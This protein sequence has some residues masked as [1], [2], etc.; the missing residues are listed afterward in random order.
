MINAVLGSLRDARKHPE[1]RKMENQQDRVLSPPQLGPTAG[2]AARP[3]SVLHIGLSF[4]C[5]LKLIISRI[6]KF[7]RN[8]ISNT[9]GENANYLT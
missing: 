7:M 2:K 5:H 4:K 9:V 6:G 8:A 1:G 3:K